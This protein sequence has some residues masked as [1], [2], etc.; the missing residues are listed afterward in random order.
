MKNHRQGAAE[1][2]PGRQCS[3]RFCWSTQK[4]W[5]S[6]RVSRSGVLSLSYLGMHSVG[7]AELRC[8]VQARD[9]AHKYTDATTGCLW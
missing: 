5:C 1:S 4:V 7:D 2:R 3:L 8:S 9:T 6:I